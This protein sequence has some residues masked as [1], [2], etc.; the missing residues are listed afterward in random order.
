MAGTG[1]PQMAPMHQMPPMQNPMQ[2]PLHQQPPGPPQQHLQ[3]QQQQQQVAEVDPVIKVRLLIP[4]LKESLSNLMK[5]AAQNFHHNAQV[6]NCSKS[7][8]PLQ[9]FDKSLEEFYSMCDQIEINLR[10]AVECNNLNTDSMKNTP[11]PVHSGKQ[12]L[13]PPGQEMQSYPQFIGTIKQQI[14]CAKEIHDSL[15]DCAKKI[16]ANIDRPV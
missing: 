10:L 5:I 4:R 16:Q 3:A 13:P 8:A 15:L 7:E 14:S 1:V 2:N 6:D 9:R 11:V 12:D